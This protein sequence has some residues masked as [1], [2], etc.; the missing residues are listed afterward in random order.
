MIPNTWHETRPDR[1]QAEHTQPDLTRT[2]YFTQPNPR[3]V[4][5]RYGY[6]FLIAGRVRVL[7]DPTHTQ[8]F[9]ILTYGQAREPH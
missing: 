9:A 2:L 1:R 3:W 7:V 4:Q 6:G 8:P 5:G